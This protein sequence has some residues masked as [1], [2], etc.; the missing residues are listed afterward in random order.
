MLQDTIILLVS[1][2]RKGYCYKKWT[3]VHHVVLPTHVSDH[4]AH[5]K[6]FGR[7]DWQYFPP[8]SHPNSSPLQQ[9]SPHFLIR[10]SAIRRHGRPGQVV[11][12]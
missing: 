4:T 7:K 11:V 5:H 10:T 6:R 8:I 3:S 2:K 1:S 9:K 12:G